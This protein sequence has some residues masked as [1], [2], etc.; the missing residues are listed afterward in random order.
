MLATFLVIV[1]GV[2]SATAAHAVTIE[3]TS[4]G[5]GSDGGQFSE[6]TALLNGEGFRFVGRRSGA[7]MFE[8]SSGNGGSL[9]ADRNG[10]FTVSIVQTLRVNNVDIISSALGGPPA[11]LTLT[12]FHDPVPSGAAGGFDPNPPRPLSPE[13]GVIRPCTITGAFTAIGFLDV[14][15]RDRVDLIGHGNFIAQW[16]G[17]TRAQYSTGFAFDAPEPATVVLLGAVIGLGAVALI[18]VQWRRRSL[19]ATR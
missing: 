4:G 11:I 7:D 13:C 2:I 19:C 14:Q 5:V 6:I 16:G 15:G 3:I 18:A 10:P 12:L 8:A 17:P 1:L 9:F